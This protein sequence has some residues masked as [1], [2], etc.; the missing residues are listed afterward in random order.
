MANLYRKR[1][2]EITGERDDALRIGMKLRQ[3]IEYMSDIMKIAL[4]ES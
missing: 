2:D 4:E 1:L 3:K